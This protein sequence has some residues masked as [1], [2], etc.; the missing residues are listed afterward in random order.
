M[1]LGAL[2]GEWENDFPE[3]VGKFIIPSDFKSMI[4][5]RD[6]QVTVDL[7]NRHQHVDP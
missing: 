4:F 3:T 7:T 5:Q 1:L 2:E 6:D